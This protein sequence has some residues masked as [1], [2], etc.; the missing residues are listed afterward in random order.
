[1]VR[2]PRSNSHLIAIYYRSKVEPLL[3]PLRLRFPGGLLADSALTRRH[4]LH[5]SFS[6]IDHFAPR[7]I[8]LN[9]QRHDSGTATAKPPPPAI[10]ST[11]AAA[12]AVQPAY[13][14]SL[15]YIDPE[16]TP[17]ALSAARALIAA[18]AS[19]T[20]QQP[21]PASSEPP[22]SPAIQAELSRI[23]ASTPQQPLDLARYEAPSS[24]APPATALPAAAVAHSYLDARLANLAL[25][26]RW[27]K[28][29]WLLGNHALEAELQ[30]LERDLAAAK[31]D[32]DLVNIDRRARQ[33][34]V[35]AEVRALDDTWRA[36]VGRV[37][38][39]EVAVEELHGRIREELARRA[40]QGVQPLGQ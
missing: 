3:H 33:D 31:R 4:I 7:E 37:L 17:D 20:Q 11:T 14:E 40:A 29:A 38:E 15:T 13:H 28:N 26:D 24:E 25:L 2:R 32:V 6:K 16:P 22:F 35:A 12:M 21:P 36:G 30:S 1:M 34:A 39:T 18:E 5:D 19:S 9:E 10:T 23:A 8:D 27:G